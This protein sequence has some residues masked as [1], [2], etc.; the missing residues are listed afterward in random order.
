MRYTGEPD[1]ASVRT[2]AI[3]QEQMNFVYS[4]DGFVQR[5]SFR[6]SPLD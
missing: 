5:L 1:F 2:D 3:F 4:L 6:I